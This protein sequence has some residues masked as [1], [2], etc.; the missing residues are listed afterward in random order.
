MAHILLIEDMPG[1]RDALGVVLTIAGH[2]IDTAGDGEQGLAKVRANAYDM[3]ICDIVMPRKDGTSVII[4][5]KAARPHL[6]ILAISGG[7]G[8]VTAKQALLVAASK[9]DRTL[10]KPFSRDDLLTA[11]R[12]T[13]ELS[14]STA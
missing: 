6:P 5:S 1:V 9:A 4:E 2:R 10:E 12:A 7:A 3:V 8:G 11:V 14:K 13:L